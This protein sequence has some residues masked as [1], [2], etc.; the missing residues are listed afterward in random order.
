MAHGRLR[1]TGSRAAAA[2]RLSQFSPSAVTVV[3][4]SVL[5]YGT[6]AFYVICRS[7]IPDD[8]L[9]VKSS[10]RVIVQIAIAGAK[11]FGKAF[12]AA[13]KQAIQSAFSILHA[14][15]ATL[16]GASQ[17]E[18]MVNELSCDIDAKYRPPGVT[19]GDVAG[20]GNATSGSLTDK[21]TREMRMTAD[22]ARMIL[23][24]KKEDPA[25][26]ILQ[27]RAAPYA[28]FMR[29][30][31]TPFPLCACQPNVCSTCRAMN[32]SS[33]QTLPPQHLQNPRLGGKHRPRTR[34]TSSRRSCAQRSDSTPSS[35]PRSRS[36]TL[37]PH[38]LPHQARQQRRP[39]LHSGGPLLPPRCRVLAPLCF[40]AC[41]YCL[42]RRL[43]ALYHPHII[44]ITTP[45]PRSRAIWSNV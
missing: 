16:H 21:L 29:S 9:L 26:K 30:A 28:F 10:P 15:C 8:I 17:A 34:T 4:G 22:E 45:T 27:V 38:H 35:R 41:I 43:N 23:N 44:T 36:R 32:T 31:P 7:K 25:E 12:A 19:G 1:G 37:P 18:G 3:A 11:I 2:R 14:F 20:V 33:R 42:H 39:L 5:G 40:R 6:S 13:G 24:V